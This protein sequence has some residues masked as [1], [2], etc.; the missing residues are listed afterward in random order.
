MKG[1]F[2]P[3][4]PHKYK[5]D[6]SN[7]IYRSSWELKAMATFDKHPSILRWNSEEV[8]IP[9]RS[10]IDGKIHRYFPDFWVEKLGR[11]GKKSVV[12]IE[13]KPYK[14]TVE[15]KKQKKM[16]KSYLY[17]VK[18]WAVNTS[19]WKAAVEYCADRG[20]DFQLMTERELGIKY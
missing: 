13:V 7:I 2:K 18:T 1:Y 4:N 9:Y 10:S 3:N 17:E 8:I 14:E 19:K 5:G 11:D 20:W 12:V 6:A 15:P 16:T